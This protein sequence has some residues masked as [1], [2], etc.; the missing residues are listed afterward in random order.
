MEKHLK[1]IL[2]IILI[3]VLFLVIRS[4]VQGEHNPQPDILPSGKIQ[5][6]FDVAFKG[7]SIIIRN[8]SHIDWTDTKVTIHV[9]NKAYHLQA[10]SIDKGETK[11]LVMSRFINDEGAVYIFTGNK[12]IAVSVY[13]NEA[14]GTV[15]I[16]N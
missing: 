3:G 16:K 8:D 12:P 14:E 13:S 15:Q 6:N 10:G 7:I 1:S 4:F 11:G 2:T 5:A 9:G